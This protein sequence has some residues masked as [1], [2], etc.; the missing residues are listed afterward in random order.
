MSYALHV[1]RWKRGAPKLATYFGD[2][3]PEIIFFQAAWQIGYRLKVLAFCI[4][5]L[6]ES[7]ASA[8]LQVGRLQ[9]RTKDG[10]PHI[11]AYERLALL[12]PPL[13]QV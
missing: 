6:T 11:V 12:H 7:L 9:V 13:Q 8:A 5:T 10:A 1:Y 4:V 3:T 2:R